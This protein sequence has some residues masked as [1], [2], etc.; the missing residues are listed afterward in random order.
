METE[1]LSV[2]AV[3]TQCA[4]W[5]R[6]VWSMAGL[7]PPSYLLTVGHRTRSPVFSI[8]GTQALVYKKSIYSLGM[9]TPLL[10]RISKSLVALPGPV[11]QSLYLG[12]IRRAGLGSALQGCSRLNSLSRR[13]SHTDQRLSVPSIPLSSGLFTHPS[14]SSHQCPSC[15]L[16]PGP[17]LATANSLGRTELLTLTRKGWWWVPDWVLTSSV[18]ISMVTCVECELNLSAW[19][20]SPSNQ[21]QPTSGAFCVLSDSRPSQLPQGLNLKGTA[22]F[23]YSNNLDV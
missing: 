16:D 7:R 20:H 18:P 1:Q 17:A 4:K 22:M 11:I 23:C 19:P 15:L 8:Q 21:P 3:R 13:R 14:L 5:S 6:S 10:P 12:P 9:A 2:W